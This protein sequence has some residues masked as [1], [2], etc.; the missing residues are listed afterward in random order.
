MPDLTRVPDREAT[1]ITADQY[2]LIRRGT[3]QEVP[4]GFVKLYHPD[5]AG[6]KFGRPSMLERGAESVIAFGLVEPH[7]A[8]VEASHPLIDPDDPRSIWR[9]EP[10]VILVA[11]GEP[12]GGPGARVVTE[13]VDDDEPPARPRRTV[14]D[15]SRRGGSRAAGG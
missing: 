9:L 2:D 13:V 10:H 6:L 11:Q 14:D 8:I 12:L 1:W 5:Y 7:F 15:A 3:I 4:P